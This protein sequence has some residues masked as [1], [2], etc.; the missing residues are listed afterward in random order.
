MPAK[1]GKQYRL[2]QAVL[3]GSITGGAD[4]DMMPKS[5]AKEMIAKTPKKKR[6]AFTK[7]LNRDD[8]SGYSVTGT[9]KNAFKV[10]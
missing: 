4:K 8:K 6:Q 1:T 2:A 3:H 10:R 7:S 5:V 9:K